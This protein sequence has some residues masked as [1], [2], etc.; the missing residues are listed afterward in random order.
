M[1]NQTDTAT[2][3]TEDSKKIQAGLFALRR[4]NKNRRQQLHKATATR[5]ERI[6]NSKI[7]G[8]N[9][10]HTEGADY[11]SVSNPPA[12]VF[13]QSSRHVSGQAFQSSRNAQ[14]DASDAMTI[15]AV[16]DYMLKNFN[17]DGFVVVDPKQ[18]QS[19]APGSPNHKAPSA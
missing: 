14:S 8:V 9:Y 2:A 6:L 15:L 18:Q 17:I 16:P 4:A 11:D 13:A 5:K 10:S 19:S 3:A 1:L 7:P 12:S